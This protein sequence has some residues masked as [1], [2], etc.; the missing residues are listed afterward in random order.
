MDLL[1]YYAQYLYSESGEAFT[2]ISTGQNSKEAM[3]YIRDHRGENVILHSDSISGWDISEL[4][5]EEY[6]IIRD[7]PWHKAYLIMVLGK[8]RQVVYL[9]CIEEG[10]EY[11]F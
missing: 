1:P 2:A 6:E 4:E 7:T 10:G 8:K 9:H 11:L 3:Q 5:N